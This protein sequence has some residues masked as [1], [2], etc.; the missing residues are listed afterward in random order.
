MAAL[1]WAWQ[2]ARGRLP[3]RGSVAD[4]RPSC[5]ARQALCLPSFS[6]NLSEEEGMENETVTVSVWHSQ[7][8]S[9]TA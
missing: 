3:R 7:C 8:L 5:Q 4:G 1:I 9:V 6:L 2:P